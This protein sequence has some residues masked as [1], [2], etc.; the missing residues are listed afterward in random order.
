MVMSQGE[1]IKIKAS[2]SKTQVSKKKSCSWGRNPESV[3][4]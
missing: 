1:V 3:D 2:N 4:V